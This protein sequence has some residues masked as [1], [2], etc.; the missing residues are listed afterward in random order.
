MGEQL[1]HCC[2]IAAFVLPGNQVAIPRN[3]ALGC[4]FHIFLVFKQGLH[5]HYIHNASAY[6]TAGG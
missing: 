1:E 3:A 5:P 4:I 6:D 2:A